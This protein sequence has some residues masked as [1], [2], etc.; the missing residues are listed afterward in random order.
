MLLQD[1]L[2]TR[3]ANCASRRDLRLTAV[4][5]R[6]P[7]ASVPIRP[8]SRWCRA[9]SCARCRWP[10]PRDSIRIG[11]TD[12]CC[13]EADSRT[14]MATSPFSPTISTSTCATERP[15]SSNSPPLQAG[16]NSYYMR[17]GET[18]PRNPAHG[19][20]HRQLFLDPGHRRFLG[21]SARRRPTTNP[22]P[23]LPLS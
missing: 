14:R 7:S 5:A 10:T 16:Q 19:I 1:D 2:V 15:S 17:R 9:F 6:W 18:E 22:E 20:C 13:V 12:D 21:P 3:C 23:R 8:S 11:D 4:A